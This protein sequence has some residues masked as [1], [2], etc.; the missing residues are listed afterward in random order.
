M[1]KNIVITVLILLLATSMVVMAQTDDP[2]KVIRTN[3]DKVL[4]VLRDPALQDESAVA[5]KKEAIRCIS[6][7]MFHWPALSK[8]VLSKNW[9]SLNPEQQ[10]EFIA[11][12]KDILEQAYIDRILTYKDEE[13]EYVGNRML[14]D[15]KAEVE[16]RIV[17]GSGP[18]SLIYRLALLNGTWGVYDVIVEGVSLTTN[19]RTQFRDFLATKSPAQLLDHLREK[20]GQT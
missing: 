19:Y 5:E 17:S 12:F 15:K 4:S 8:R 18:V 11:L 14:S 16:T 6:N 9:A 7:N 20:V 13:I 1:K 2:L 10:Q 3:I